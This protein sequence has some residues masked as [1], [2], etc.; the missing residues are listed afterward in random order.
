MSTN[1]NTSHDFS[2]SELTGLPNS[3]FKKNQEN[4]ISNLKKMLTGLE[5]D[6]L[7]ILQGGVEI[8]RDDTDVV[9]YHFQQEG[10]FYYL[11]GVTD[12]KF[13]ATLDI[14][15]SQMTLYYD[16]EKDER[17]NI[18]MKIPSLKELEEKYETPVKN[19]SDFYTELKSRS[20]KKMYVLNGTNSELGLKIKPALLKFPEENFS[21]EKLVD[22]K[23]FIYEI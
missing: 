6:S 13:Y 23:P 19:M 2:L 12:P 14:K 21:L 20:P 10:N 15:S 22:A 5:E 11:T 18:F 1:T 8:P 7:L 9:V 16:L 4:F 17:L 3:Y